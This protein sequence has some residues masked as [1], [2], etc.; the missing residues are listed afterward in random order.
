M[1]N[2]RS[3]RKPPKALVKMNIQIA[4]VFTSQGKKVSQ[5]ALSM[6][7]TPFQVGESHDFKTTMTDTIE[8]NIDSGKTFFDISVCTGQICMGFEADTNLISINRN[9]KD[10]GVVTIIRHFLI[11]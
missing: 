5:E 4:R 8:K 10:R 9:I 1:R 2:K 7:T 3:S 6:R 11:F